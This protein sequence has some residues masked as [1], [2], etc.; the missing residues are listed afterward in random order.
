MKWLMEQGE[1]SLSG[2]L[3]PGH[4]CTIAGTKEY[5]AFKVPQVIAGFEPLEVLYGL[6]LLVKQVVEGRAEVENA[7]PRAVKPEGNVKALRMMGE[8]FDVCDIVWRGFPSIPGS[9]LS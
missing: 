3:L 5:E 7:Y 2:F 9:G 4:V 1:A 8:V 6:Y